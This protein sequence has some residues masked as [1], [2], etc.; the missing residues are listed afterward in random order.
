ML[1]RIVPRCMTACLLFASLASTA[2]IYVPD[3]HPTIQGAIDA[4]AA[5][6]TIIVRPGTY[7]ENINDSYDRPVTLKSELGP[8][9]TVIDGNRSGSVVIFDSDKSQGS[10]IEGF[11]IRNGSGRFDASYGG[12]CGGGIYCTE[13]STP[14]ITGNVVIG[15]AAQCGGGVFCGT[16]SSAKM[17]NNIVTMNTADHG[18]GIA[19]YY[20]SPAIKITNNTVALNSAS[21]AGGGI[22]LKFLDLPNLKITN[23]IV[24]DNYAPSDPEL[25]IGLIHAVAVTCCDVKGGWP[26]T[27][28]IDSDPLFVDTS[29]PSFLDFHLTFDSPCRDKGSNT[30]PKIPE[31]DFEGDPRIASATADIGADEFHYHLYHSGDVVPAGAIEIKVVGGPG[32]GPVQ[33]AHGSGIQDPPLATSYGDF[34][35]QLPLLGLYG[36]GPIPA[37]GVLVFPGTVPSWWL[38][39]ERHPFQ[40]L[41]GPMAPGS[42]LTNLM[43]L[44]L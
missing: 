34:F 37:D 5:G 9:Y 33:L 36:L 30:A 14:V 42:R 41:V 39:G 2:T 7:A 1:P 43:I 29:N 3:D 10:V 8:E 24:W 6:D 28:N 25:C 22:F 26:G 17:T 40:A 44:S 4:A 31:L 38:P 35:L 21:L 12:A 16:Q 13:F 18:G 20:A 23:T 32:M 27:G 11:T 15:N 19:C